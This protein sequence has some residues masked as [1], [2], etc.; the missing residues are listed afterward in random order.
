MHGKKG[1]EG[2]LPSM[3]Q[4]AFGLVEVIFAGA[5]LAI[6]SLGV[7]ASMAQGQRLNAGA[8][9]DLAAWNALSATRCEIASAG[10]NGVAAWDQAAFDVA[11]LRPAAA[12]P[13]GKTGSVALT[14]VS[15][16]GRFLYYEVTL[17][18][19]WN[20][21]LGERSIKDTSRI[22]NLGGT[23]DPPPLAPAQ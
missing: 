18:V 21:A 3:G 17:E 7:T 12:D 6:A 9:E 19:S 23:I 15:D 20:G 8:R 4:H 16:G 14:Y 11:G 13:D 2:N 1:R 22:T 10:I 5:V